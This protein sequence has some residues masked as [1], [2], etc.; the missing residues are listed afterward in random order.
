MITSRFTDVSALIQK[1]YCDS[2]CGLVR[3]FCKKMNG[4]NRKLTVAIIVLSNSFEPE[5][6]ATGS[7]R[8][9]RC[10]AHCFQVFWWGQNGNFASG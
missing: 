2:L 10:L 4:K 1:K 8:Q 5:N 6:P 7:L 3:A 9:K